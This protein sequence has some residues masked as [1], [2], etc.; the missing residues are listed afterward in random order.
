MRKRRAR[1]AL[2]AQSGEIKVYPCSL[3]IVELVASDNNRT[4][5]G[6]FVTL[7][8]YLAFSVGAGCCVWIL[9]PKP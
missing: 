1:H 6:Y 7:I 4:I 5:A 9:A 2:L 3:H 8:D